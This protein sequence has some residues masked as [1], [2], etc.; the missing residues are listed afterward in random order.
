MKNEKFKTK[1]LKK[2]EVKKMSRNR[3]GF[4]LIELLVVIAIIAIL[5]AMLLPAL[6]KAREKARGAV[7]MNNLKQIG[8]AIFMFVADS[9]S[10]ETNPKN[11]GSYKEPHFPLP[12]QSVGSSGSDNYWFW[13]QALYNLGYVKNEEI[14]HC[15]SDR[16]FNWKP[17]DL[18][19]NTWRLDH[20][21]ILHTISY[22]YNVKGFLGNPGY[23]ELQG[24]DGYQAIGPSVINNP[25][26]KIMV[27]DSDGDEAY[28]FVITV[29]KGGFKTNCSM[30]GYNQG[31]HYNRLDDELRPV[32]NRH[33]G[34]ANI[35]YCDGH[36]EW[37]HQ[38]IVQAYGTADS[39]PWRVT[40]MMKVDYTYN[41]H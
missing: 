19:F 23:N 14:F 16:T 24:P 34:G 17:E 1:N 5:A 6:S 21:N 26:E 30:A 22:G 27:A 7:C 4:T 33:N 29:A 20:E 11:Y 35:L 37:R 31:A 2:G 38:D 9:G 3:K 18:T 41:V 25:S 15:P 40:T 10:V 8:L 32:G 28:D 36:V 13:F 12:W 39:S